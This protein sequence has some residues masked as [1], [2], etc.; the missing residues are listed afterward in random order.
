MDSVWMILIFA[1]CLGLLVFVWWRQRRY[2]KK[3]TSEAMRDEIWDEILEE[4]ET[5]LRKKRLFK[6]SLDKA[7]QK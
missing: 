6:A 5:A 1:V 2:L 3:K 7:L 4:R